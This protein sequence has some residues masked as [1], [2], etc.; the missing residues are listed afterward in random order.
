MSGRGA[1]FNGRPQAGRRVSRDRAP[2]VSRASGAAPASDSALSDS[3]EEDPVRDGGEVSGDLSDAVASPTIESRPAPRPESPSGPA[4]QKGLPG[5]VGREGVK[6]RTRLRITAALQA[7]PMGGGPMDA[8]PATPPLRSDSAELTDDADAAPHAAEGPKDGLLA[9][10]RGRNGRGRSSRDGRSGGARGSW[11]RR[12]R[13][14]A[15]R[16]QR[17]LLQML[18]TVPPPRR[19]A[20]AATGRISAMS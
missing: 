17:T 5:R 6:A 14:S 12:R 13:L 20:L 7:E 19:A 18:T 10:E 2:R 1:G 3:G 9:K 8:Q 11:G 4:S 16:G 15:D